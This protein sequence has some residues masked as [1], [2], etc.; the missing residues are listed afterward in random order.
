MAFAAI[1]VPNFKLQAVVRCEPELAVRPIA[2]IDG[3]P[4]TYQVV[5]VN[6]LAARLGVAE[7]MTKAAAT[8]F[9][10]VE[11]R[12][13]G[14]LQETTAHAVLLDVAWSFS[15]RMEDTTPD[16]VLIDVDGLASLFGVHEI[17]RQAWFRSVRRWG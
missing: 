12:P 10:G 16:T 2:L 5:A 17:L 7:G 1:F 13:R 14:K 4:P 11:I 9:P 15:P 8:Q 3:P 6:R